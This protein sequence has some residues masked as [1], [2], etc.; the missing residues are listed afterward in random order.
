[1]LKHKIKWF[2]IKL[3]IFKYTFVVSPFVYI[4]N[5]GN[6]SKKITDKIKWLETIKIKCFYKNMERDVLKKIYTVYPEYKGFIYLY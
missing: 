4:D 5:C 3:N 6:V 1:M 2:L